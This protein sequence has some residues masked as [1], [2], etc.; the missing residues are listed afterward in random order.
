MFLKIDQIM[1]IIFICEAG[2]AFLVFGYSSFEII[3]NSCVK[4]CFSFICEDVHEH[5]NLKKISHPRRDSK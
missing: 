3:C 4:S 5:L 1:T 2:L